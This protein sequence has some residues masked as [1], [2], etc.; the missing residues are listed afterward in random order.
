MRKKAKL[1]LDDS[2]HAKQ[3][4]FSIPAP[5]ARHHDAAAL[6]YG[7]AA[8]HQRQ[9]AKLNRSTQYEKASPCAQLAD[10]DPRREVS[11]MEETAKA[12]LKKHPDGSR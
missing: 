11:H 3:P 5:G 8:R 12:D 9:A 4:D 10:G 7:E 6:H 1:S 2:G